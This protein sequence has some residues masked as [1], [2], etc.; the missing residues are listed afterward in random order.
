MA[1]RETYYRYEG[2]VNDL[3]ARLSVTHFYVVRRTAKGAWIASTWDHDGSYAR[4][5]LDGKGKRFAY[6]NM[7]D[8]RA[9][10]IIRKLRQIGHAER[11]LDMARRTLALAQ[12]GADAEPD[13]FTFFTGGGEEPTL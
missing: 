2:E 8:A 5:V 9:S 12:S 11:T 4:F 1:E 7:E 3:G 13:A 10:F 6:P